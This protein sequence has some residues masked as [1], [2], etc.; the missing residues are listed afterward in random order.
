MTLL[1]GFLSSAFLCV[2]AL[3]T[4]MSFVATA[5]LMLVH[6]KDALHDE[7][8]SEYD[9]KERCFSSTDGG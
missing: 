1:S 4:G 3:S 8:P 2:S 9:V 5:L 6:M 7:S